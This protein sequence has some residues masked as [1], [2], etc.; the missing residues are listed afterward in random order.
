[1][2]WVNFASQLYGQAE[3]LKKQMI[4]CDYP[5]PG[6]SSLAFYCPV[7]FVV[8]VQNFV[9][10]QNSLTYT[11]TFWDCL[12]YWKQKNVL[13]IYELGIDSIC[14]ISKSSLIFKLF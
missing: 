11:I 13:F 10:L 5:M 6:V 12:V 4:Y 1:M 8:V 3:T 14:I 2:F 7:V 9:K